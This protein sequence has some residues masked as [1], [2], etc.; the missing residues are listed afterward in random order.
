MVAL[1]GVFIQDYMWGNVWD[2]SKGATLDI[3]F[4]TPFKN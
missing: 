1:L 3:C 2:C 4:E